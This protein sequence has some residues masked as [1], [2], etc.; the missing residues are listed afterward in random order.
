MKNHTCHDA[1]KII[2]YKGFFKHL[3][4]YEVTFRVYPLID[5]DRPGIYYVILKN[6]DQFNDAAY[7]VNV[8]KDIYT[9]IDFEKTSDLVRETN[10]TEYPIKVERKKGVT[11]GH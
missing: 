9:E 3:K 6:Q 4:Y 5:L 7:E 1:V 10:L 2:K 8:L 11:Y